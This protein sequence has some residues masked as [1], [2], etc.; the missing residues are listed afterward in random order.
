MTPDDIDAAL[1]TAKVRG[2]L[3]IA[4]PFNA[5]SPEHTK[6]LDE[7]NGVCEERGRHRVL[8]LCTGWGLWRTAVA[9]HAGA[10]AEMEYVRH[11]F[12]EAFYRHLDSGPRK[13]DDAWYGSTQ[14]RRRAEALAFDL[15]VVDA[16]PRDP[17][18]E[19]VFVVNAR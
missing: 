9:F 2:Y 15:A 6:L 13:E 1:S 3:V 8:V 12:E 18:F 19:D 4:E 5:E 11:E 17:Q 7:W 16:E 10:D 14:H